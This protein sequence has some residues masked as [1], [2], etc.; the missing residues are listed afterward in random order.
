MQISVA[1]RQQS[2]VPPHVVPWLSAP[3]SALVLVC[4]ILLPAITLLVEAVTHMCANVFFDP[5]PTVGHLFAIATVPLANLASLWTLR[6]REAVRIDAVIFAQAV[7]VAVAGVHAVMFIRMTPLAVYGVL[8][9]G[10]GLLPLSPLLSLV[11]GLK[12]LFALRAARG[13]LGRPARRMVLGG[14]AAGVGVLIALN[15]PAIATR[16]LMARAAS[17]DPATSLAAIGWLRRVGQQDLM[18]RAAARRRGV[19][20]VAG[21]FLDVVAPVPYDKTSGIY[22]RVTGRPIEDEPAPRTGAAGW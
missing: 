10:L 3:S 12:A 21:A 8:Y 9:L 13:T 5:L 11:A 17:D 1:P 4:G 22:D 7:A 18:L 2:S 6:R 14:L 19:L 16:V 20:D 15:I